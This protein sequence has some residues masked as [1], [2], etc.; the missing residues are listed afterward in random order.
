VHRP[1]ELQHVLDTH[2]AEDLLGRHPTV[3]PDET[4]D[5]ENG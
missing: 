2:Y 5:C 4:S 3:E 1:E